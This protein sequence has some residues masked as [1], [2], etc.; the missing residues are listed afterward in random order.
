VACLG[1]D[2]EAIVRELSEK[3]EIPRLAAVALVNRGYYDEKSVTDYVRNGEILLHDPFLL[4]DMDKACDIVI[5]AIKNKDK[6][7]VYGD[8]DVDGVTATALVYS[9]LKDKGADVVYYIPDRKTEGYGM[10]MGSVEKIASDGV[11]LIVTVDNGITA[12]DEI[13]YAKELGMKVVV[14]DHHSCHEV[15]PEADAAINPKIPGCK[16]PYTELAG[17]G[18]AFKTVC[19]V[20]SKLCETDGR[21]VTEAV[22]ELCL[23]Y[24]D[25]VAIGTVADVMPIR[26]ENRLLCAMGMYT[27]DKMPSTAIDALMYMASLG[28]TICASPEY[29]IN[30]PR[31]TK[32]RKI[33]SSYI[34]FVLAPRINAAGRVT[35]ANDAL[36]LLLS[37]TKKEAIESAYALCSI[38]NA[39]KAMEGAIFDEAVRTLE[40]SGNESEKIIVLDSDKWQHGVIGIVASRILEKYSLPVILISFEDGMSS[41]LQSPADVGKGSCRSIKGF[42]IHAALDSCSDLFVRYGGHEL[43]AGLTI[44][45]ENLDEFKRRICDYARDR[46]NVEADPP[47]VDIDCRAELSELTLECAN[48][49]AAF[50]PYG[51]GNPQPVFCSEHVFVKKIMSLAQGK[52]CRVL[53]E[54]GDTE[55]SALCFA[56]GP[57]LLPVYEGEYADIAYTIEVNNFKGVSSVQVNLEDI[58]L[59]E[60]YKNEIDRKKKELSAFLAGDDGVRFD[61]E[62][63]PQRREFAVLYAY[64]RRMAA[65]GISTFSLRKTA[66]CL[67]VEQ[68]VRISTVVLEVILNSF[69]ELGLLLTDKLSDD[70]YEVSLPNEIKKA[71]LSASTVLD[72]FR[73]ACSDS[74]K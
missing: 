25:I 8:Y 6:I 53:V 12:V 59:S 72:R 35:H 33:N 24:T 13:A 15:L 26:D 52:Y 18:V 7:C 58:R 21:S 45:R 9:Y 34:G 22:K 67:M 5:G 54:Q 29:Y 66:A 42:D 32:R 43:A 39:R 19:A 57:E 47:G 49:L 40:S 55:I 46:I 68:G 3:L 14:T 63:C 48:T 50:E 74:N 11:S 2:K 20:E 41:E 69:R 70:I 17:V 23:R 37:Q 44:L 62:I 36:R 28:D 56:H 30:K 71:D 60:K 27:L 10:N 61:G 64:V 51:T 16:Y 4:T 73:K 31:D 65:E 1:E 38:N